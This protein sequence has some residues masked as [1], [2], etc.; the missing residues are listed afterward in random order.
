[1]NNIYLKFT[2][3]KS[4]S[5][6][7][8]A[9][10]ARKTRSVR[11]ILYLFKNPV[12]RLRIL[13]IKLIVLLLVAIPIMGIAQQADST[14]S[15][16]DQYIEISAQNNP[17]LK[18]EYRS[19]LAALEKVPQVNTLPDPELSFGYF[20]NPIETRVGPQQAR[21]GLTQMFP[22]FGTLGTRGEAATQMAKAKFEAFQEA[23]NK[24]FF[25]VQEKWY[26]LYQIE[27]SILIMQENIDILDTFESLA[28]RRYESG[29]VGQVDVLRVQI[30][31]EDL[32]TRLELIKDNQMVSARK[33]NEFLNR[34]KGEEIVVPDSLEIR[35]LAFPLQ[36][37]EELVIQQNSK[38]TM[39]GFQASS[40]RSSISL[41]QKE[42]LPKFGLGVD[43]IVTGKRDMVIPDNGQD[44]LMVRAGIQIPLYRK[45]YQAK[46][47][48]ARIELHSVQDRQNS[49]RNK[50]LTQLEQAMRDY[51]DAQR[52]LSLYRDKQIQRTRQAINILTE[53]YATSAT[54]FE[55]LL[56]LQRKLLDYELAR[57][58]A[59][60]DQNTAV[61][62][63]EYLYGKYNINLQS[64]ESINQ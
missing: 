14:G 3:T 21:V 31:K 51:R 32:N 59:L 27:Q 63:I 55:E 39:L 25:D 6:F 52:R 37:L 13:R 23:R 53:Q 54:D 34:T 58:T 60:V 62:Y 40:A 28:M 26:Q 61:A 18:A 43:Y 5:D 35:D 16:I 20:I 44:A 46:E 1:M 64:V 22:W 49:A 9:K 36:E 48:Q 7:F 12:Y 47:K 38:L 29:Q 2:P 33:F 56:R 57:E 17:A 4:L 19:Y 24:L 30:E 50:L 45:K 42:G 41:A 11:G 10:C 15:Q 8:T